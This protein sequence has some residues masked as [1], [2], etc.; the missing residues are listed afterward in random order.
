MPLRNSPPTV[1]SLLS[2]QVSLRQLRA[3]AAVV[4]TGSAS[5]AAERLHVTQSAVSKTVAELEALLGQTLVDRRNRSFHA[6]ALGQPLV[7]L[8]QRLQ[9][10]LDRCGQ[11]V[12]ALCRGTQGALHVGATNAALAHLL[13]QAMAQL[14]AEQPNAA[15][16]V[17]TH[18]VPDMVDDLR[19]GRL[20]L[21]VARLRG[22]DLPPDLIGQRLMGQREVVV[23]SAHHPLA[24]QRSWR[25]EQ[26]QDQAW[27][28]PFEGTQSR[29]LL[30]RSWQ[31]RGLTPPSNQIATGDLALT[32]SLLRRMPMLA[33]MALQQAELAA[34]LGIA[35]ILPLQADLGL[36]DLSVWWHRERLSP[37]A[38]Q[39]K[40][41]LQDVAQMSDAPE[42]GP[43][44]ARP[45]TKPSEP[46]A[47]PAW[48]ASSPP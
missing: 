5:L 42:E 8:A 37:L 36:P 11:E 45:A 35:K 44:A 30:E 1:G 3:L 16:H 15:L 33:F 48:R 19:S 39:F 29:T 34:R 24:L 43:T 26:L 25:W 7:E 27:I 46:P 2:R 12:D 4:E 47:A 20:D 41:V 38:E 6:T 31:R 23:I 32:F 22:D 9:N 13:P 17:H 40:A 18:A 14:K 21:V 28:I 10:E